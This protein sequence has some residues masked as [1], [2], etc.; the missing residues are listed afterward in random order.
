MS[1]I[2]R[3]H[4]LRN[5]I[6]KIYI[7]IS[8]AIAD[9]IKMVTGVRVQIKWP[10]DILLKDRKIGGVLIEPSVRKKYIKFII[11]GIGI[12]VNMD[13]YS[14]PTHIKGKATSLKDGLKKEIPRLKLL[15]EILKKIEKYYLEFMNA[16]IKFKWSGLSVVVGKP[17]KIKIQNNVLKKMD[18]D[19][20]ADKVLVVTLN[21]GFLKCA[22][23]F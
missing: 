12:D 21:K 14:F 5:E 22:V 1:V 7:I 16:L 13:K 18:P 6:P 20:K 11:V 23:S 17:V 3:P 4:I 15:K 9:A 19:G 8:L 2:L 10:N